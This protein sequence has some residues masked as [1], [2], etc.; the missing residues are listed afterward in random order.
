MNFVRNSI[1]AF[2]KWIISFIEQLLFPND[3][4]FIPNERFK[5]IENLESNYAE[6]L[7]EFTTYYK[8]ND[9]PYFDEISSSQK[10]IVQK[11]KWK[12]IILLLINK[13]NP[14]YKQSFPNT[15]E[16]ILAI[17]NVTSAIISVL[18]KDTHILPHRGVYK[19]ILRCHLGI[20]IPTDKTNCY[21]NVNGKIKNWEVGKCFVFD[22]TFQHEALNK[23]TESRVILM[24][25]FLRPAKS[26]WKFMLNKWIVFLISK[27]PLVKEINDFYKFK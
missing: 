23:T 2:G 22:D 26:K 5:W 1:T 13:I 21:I 10:K 19:G 18:E 11:K 20:I 12:S 6:I 16:L 25:D 14:V 24:I 4:E 27:S 8:D 3:N 15:N 17:P 9:I 7:R